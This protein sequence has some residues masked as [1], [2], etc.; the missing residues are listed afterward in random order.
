MSDVVQ[1]TP[2]EQFKPIVNIESLTAEE[3]QRAT[4][5]AATIKIDDP[6]AI[7]QYGVGAQSKISGFADT[8]LQEVRTKDTG[9]VGEALQ[10]LV[11]NIKGVGID[12]LGESFT[13]GV[14][15]LRRIAKAIQKFIGQYEKLSVQI[16]KITTALDTARMNLLKDITLLENLYNKNVEYLKELDV[17]IA[18]G[19]MKLKEAAEK[20]LPELKAK[21]EA[22]NDPIDAQKLQD[23][24]QFVNRFEKKLYDL[25]L[26]RMIS[27]QTGPQIRLIQNNNQTLVEKIQS[28]ILNTIPLWKN[29]IVIA[30]SLFR[31]KKAL[32]VQKQVTETTNELLRKNSELLKNSSI[33]IAKESERG[34]VDIETLKKV[35]ADL[36]TTLEETLKIQ[37]EGK[38]KRQQAEV[39][40]VK[41]ESE[42]KTQ[43]IAIK[44]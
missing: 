33:E 2:Q 20:I 5:I 29:Q 13:S 8:I 23:F 32:E 18:A 1:L 31:Q 22:S 7:T 27:I 19:Q 3:K 42:L 35:N 11:I 25:K 4:D 43:L 41:M 30:I 12:K 38:V 9:Y 39:E 21:A 17:Y 16:E 34:I 24:S 37:A 36:I 44:G 15:I 28:S 26:S 10:D 6:N 40:L 14:P